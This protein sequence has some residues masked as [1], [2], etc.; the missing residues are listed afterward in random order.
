MGLL[1]KSVFI[2][3]FVVTIPFLHSD[4]GCLTQLLMLPSLLAGGFPTLTVSAGHMITLG[5]IS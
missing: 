4:P 3:V 1:H 2:R 5:C